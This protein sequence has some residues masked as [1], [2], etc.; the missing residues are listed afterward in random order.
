MGNSISINRN[1]S[2]SFSKTNLPYGISSHS[3]LRSGWSTE[4]LTDGMKNIPHITKL[5]FNSIPEYKNGNETG[6]YLDS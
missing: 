6:L 3:S 2:S 4:E 5:L 1:T